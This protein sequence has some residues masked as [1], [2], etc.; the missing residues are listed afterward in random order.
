MLF[1][2]GLKILSFLECVN[3]FDKDIWF[4]YAEKN[5]AS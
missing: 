5:I 1:F 4:F 3:I 2:I